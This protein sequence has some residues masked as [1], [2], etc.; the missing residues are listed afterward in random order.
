MHRIANKLT[1]HWTLPPPAAGLAPPAC[2]VACHTA[3]ANDAG[4]IVDLQAETIPPGANEALPVAGAWR[5]GTWTVEWNRPL[6]SANANDLQFT[7]LT[8]SYPFFIKIFEGDAE[9]ADPV[10]SLHVMVFA[11]M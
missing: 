7:D 9:R 2:E 5:D 3:Y 10:S 11:G 8:A 4:H 1:V 6:H